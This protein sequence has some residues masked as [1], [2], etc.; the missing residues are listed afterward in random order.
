MRR[1]RASSIRRLRALKNISWLTAPQLEKLALAL[2]VST[3]E[4]R[5]IIF[6]EKHSPDSAFIL[7]AGVAR[8]T[9]RNR[10]GQRTSVIMI[11]PGMIPG[12]PPP[13]PGI[14]YN[15]RC[16]AVTPC[17]IGMIDL[18]AF[19]EISLGVA[20]AD[21]KRMAASYMGRWDL[22]QLRCA[23]F[24][25][26]TLEERLAL[27]LLEL[28]ENFGVPDAKGTRLTLPARHKDLAE[29]VGASRPRITEH[30]SMF[31]RQHLIARDNRQL[32]IDRDRL[33]SFLAQT[34]VSENSPATV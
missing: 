28:S 29:L 21:F 5:A 24:M 1:V 10:K 4:K 26:C 30:M 25:N 33:E 32:I 15:F 7:L 12:F 31:E 3:V 18:A 23:N 22:V 27:T 16:E 11:A 2:T 6:D 34:Q 20:S 17:Q 14:S 13:V 9:C 8:I 19:L